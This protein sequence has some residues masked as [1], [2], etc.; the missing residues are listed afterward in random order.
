MTPAVRTDYA[1]VNVRGVTL[2]TFNDVAKGRAW[3]RQNAVLHDGLH[4]REVT[5]T[6]KSRRIYAAP[7][8]AVR[9]ND[10]RF[11]SSPG[12]PALCA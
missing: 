12:E 4:L 8:A 9:R 11:P 3:V 7:A 1:A 6:T 5:I 10:F 2:C